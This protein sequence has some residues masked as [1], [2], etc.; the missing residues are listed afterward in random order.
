MR[1]FALYL[2]GL[3]F[4]LTFVSELDAQRS[5]EDRINA[6]RAGA[7]EAA[8]KKKKLEEAVGDVFRIRAFGG[9]HN[10][11]ENHS[12]ASRAFYHADS[13]GVLSGKTY[14]LRFFRNE[15][16]Y[17]ISRFFAK[18]N[19]LQEL[20]ASFALKFGDYSVEIIGVDGRKTKGVSPEWP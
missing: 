16:S 9:L 15:T 14:L 1:G 3:L 17:S 13:L 10:L 8:E 18:G 19:H 12:E 4:T 7:L 20:E 2:L 6:R 11:G 5:Y